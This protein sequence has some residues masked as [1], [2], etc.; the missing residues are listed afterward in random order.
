MRAKFLVRSLSG[1]PLFGLLVVG[2]PAR[3]AGPL[4]LPRQTPAAKLAQQVGLTEIAV[5]YD[6][7][8]VRGRKIWGGV[9]P[10]DRPWTTG[11][12]PAAKI[13]FS[14]D[15]TIGDKLVPA[16]T[17]WLLATPGKATWTFMIN[18]SP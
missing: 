2:R 13:K 8:A 12:S 17:Y 15:V 1:L 16:G 3:A 5:E 4:E 11:A 6:R 18:K 10:Y 7:P 14:R 9:V